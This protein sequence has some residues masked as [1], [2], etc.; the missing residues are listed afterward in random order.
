M[1]STEKMCGLFQRNRERNKSR[2]LVLCYHSVISDDSPVNSRTNIAVF[3]SAF[4]KQIA[5]IR[6][7]WHPVSLAEVKSACLEKTPCPDYSV[8]VTFDDGFRNNYTL[9]A[10]ILKKYEVP[11]VVFLT[12]G[13][14]ENKELLWPQEIRERIVGGSAVAAKN[15]DCEKNCEITA[16]EEAIAEC[17]KMSRENRTAYLEELRKSTTLNLEQP[18]KK[19][20]YEFMTWDEVRRI[21]QF[22]VDLGGHTVTHPI[23]STL[24]RENLRDELSLCK[25]KIEFELGEECF[26]F[27]YPNGG[28]ADF[29]DTVIE[30]TKQAGF[31]IAFNLLERRNPVIL[32]PMSIDRFCITGDL[33]LLE[34]EKLLSK[35]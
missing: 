9:A 35:H 29:N 30:E 21:R 25:S 15:K 23:L 12:T 26:S 27:A 7:H 34:F 17:K 1:L 22:G 8:L 14:I 19:E 33:S 28:R 20:L 32:N 10:P 13:L 16:A 4:E 6:N 11:A 18:W 5:L 24:S 31:Q 3:K 2:F